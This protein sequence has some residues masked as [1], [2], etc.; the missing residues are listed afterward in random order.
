MVE[1]NK[2]KGKIVEVFNTRKA[3]AEAMGVTAPYVHML[4][5]GK[6]KW[7]EARILQAMEMLGISE[8]DRE[9]YFNEGVHHEA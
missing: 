6:T 3:F 7:P 4:L 8:A 9:V 1:I 5:E 2:L